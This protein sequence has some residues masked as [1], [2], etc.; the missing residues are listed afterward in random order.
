VSLAK[1]I[2]QAALKKEKEVFEVVGWHT[3]SRLNLLP[4]EPSE[5]EGVYFFPCGALL[6]HS[7]MHITFPLLCQALHV[8]ALKD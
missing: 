1:L 2:L 3:Q 6:F 8:Y 5:R 7:D 4:S